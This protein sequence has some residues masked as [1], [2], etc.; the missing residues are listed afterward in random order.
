M[1]ASKPQIFTLAGESGS[2]KTTLGRMIL[3]NIGPTSGNVLYKN[4]DIARIKSRK[5]SMWY[6]KEAQPIFQ[7]PFETFNPF[8][9]I[10]KYFFETLVNFNIVDSKKDAIEIIEE[11]LNSIGLSFKEIEGRYPNELS[12]GQIQRCSIARALVTNPS[13]LIADEPTS[14]VDASLRMSIVN[15]FKELKEKYNVSIIYITHDLAIAYYISDFIAI[16]LRGS[17]V[18]MG[19][20]EKILG[21]PKHPY[22]KL[23]KESVPN[24]D[25][26]RKWRGKV[27]MPTLEMKEFTKEG[28]KFVDRC[29]YRLDICVQEEPEGFVKDGRFLK[30]HLQGHS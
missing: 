20:V 25:P 24:P 10:D 7:N 13:M 8:K 18:E 3:N 19:P 22:T 28:C 4:I 9:R 11:T 27:K 29:P 12:G 5:K 15:L 2:G 26:E 16:M 30:C 21:N 14:M 6:M 23:L 17:I 1:K